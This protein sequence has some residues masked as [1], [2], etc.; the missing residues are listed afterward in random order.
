M[1]GRREGGRKEG[2]EGVKYGYNYKK[3]LSKHTGVCLSHVCMSSLGFTH[4]WK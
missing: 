2:R 1:E 4:L 3:S